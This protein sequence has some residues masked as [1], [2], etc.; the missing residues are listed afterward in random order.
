MKA[1]ALIAWLMLVI[2]LSFAHLA[3]G[4]DIEVDG[5]LVDMGQDPESITVGEPFTLMLG[6]SNASTGEQLNPRKV[7]VR[8]MKDGT[9]AF[10][11]T[12]SPEARSMS[13]VM[14]FPK[15]GVYTM[16]ARFFGDGPK[17]WAAVEFPLTVQ[18]KKAS[19]MVM[20]WIVVGLGIAVLMIVG[21][22]WWKAKTIPYKKRGV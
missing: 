11:G 19:G 10:A 7:W 13:V 18:V 17:A 14:S 16:D 8:I 22:V 2:P 6:I 3:A 12:F 5:Y 15:E 4:Q 9:I 20:A 21:Y 1:V